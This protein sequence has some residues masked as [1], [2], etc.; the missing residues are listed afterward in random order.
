MQNFFLLHKG[1]SRCK[2]T[3]KKW[4]I[5]F[6]KIHQICKFLRRLRRT[7]IPTIRRTIL[8]IKNKRR[9]RRRNSI[10]TPPI[11]RRR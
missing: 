4:K 5:D 1:F 10:R 7:Q 8:A 2:F 3:S 6:N 11:R 9:R